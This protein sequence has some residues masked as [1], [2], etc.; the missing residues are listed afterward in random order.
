M[1][2]REAVSKVRSLNKLLSQ[3]NTISDRAI[4]YEIESVSSL[5]IKRETD[6]RKLWESDSIFTTVKCLKMI[7]VPITDCCSYTSPCTIS[8]SVCKIPKIGEGIYNLLVLPVTTIDGK[9]Q[10]SEGSA[11]RYTNLLDLGLR[12]KKNMMF[13]LQNG[14]LYVSEKVK[15]VNL[16]AYFPSGE[17]LIEDVKCTCE[18][19]E[20]ILNS[21][22]PKNPLDKEWK[23]PEYLS[24][25]VITM[26]HEKFNKIY[27]RHIND[28]QSDITKDDQR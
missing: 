26:V 25:N 10:F 7:E 3:D 2:I 16:T 21:L 14:Y 18:S 19:K 12:G 1:T 28:P 4:M 8:R 15:A 11:N 27:F 17:N 23:V 6:A 9:L 5:L 22:C 13:W 24:D 20:S